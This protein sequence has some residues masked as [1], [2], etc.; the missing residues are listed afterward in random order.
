MTPFQ[1][2]I[3]TTHAELIRLTIAV[4]EDAD[5]APA[6]FELFKDMEEAG[7]TDLVKGMIDFVE[8]RDIDTEGLDDEDEAILMAMQRG[9]EDGDF[10]A[11][12]E[13]DAA[14]VA[15]PALAALIYAAT[16]GELEALETLAGL[17][18]AAD[19]PTAIATAEALIAMVEGTR[20]AD[21]LVTGL[22]DEQA[23][24][25]RAVMQH[26]IALET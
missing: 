5:L 7:W 14:A 17:R 22:P 2:Q 11:E 9:H 21:T 12:L 26:L 15:A 23:R 1:R 8:G 18:E 19:T 13:V 10:L 4:R 24:L 3:A 25:M 20:D 16:Q 6:L